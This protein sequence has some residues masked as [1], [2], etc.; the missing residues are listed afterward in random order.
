MSKTS[1]ALSELQYMH[2]GKH[3]SSC[4]EL[5]WLSVCDLILICGERFGF[6]CIPRPAEF[7]RSKINNFSKQICQ[8]DMSYHQF[9][10]AQ[11][12]SVHLKFLGKRATHGESCCFPDHQAHCLWPALHENM[13]AL[14]NAST[15]V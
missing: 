10:Q 5:H 8:K 11:L 1:A 13:A 9:L 4:D 15:C 7:S 3:W 2:V 12:T 14:F 6:A